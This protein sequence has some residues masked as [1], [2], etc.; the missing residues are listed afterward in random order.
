MSTN[1]PKTARLEARLPES[2]RALLD[3]A[4]A[5]QGRS[6]TDFVVSS[7]REAAERTIAEHKLLTI[8]VADQQLFAERLL[9][10]SPIANPLKQAARSRKGLVEPS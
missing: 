2:V 9:S 10:P 7:A 5:L 1:D 4:A 3:Q 6:L 8:S